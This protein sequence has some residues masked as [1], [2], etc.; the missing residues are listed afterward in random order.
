MENGRRRVW[1]IALGNGVRC[2]GGRGGCGAVMAKE[3]K[4]G[5]MD[6]ENESVNRRPSEECEWGAREG[7]RDGGRDKRIG[8]DEARNS[9][10][11]EGRGASYEGGRQG[12]EDRS[13]GSGNRQTRKNRRETEAGR[14]ERCAAVGLT[15]PIR[16]GEGE[17]EALPLATTVCAVTFTLSSSSSNRPSCSII[18]F[19]TTTSRVLLF[20]LLC[21]LIPPSSPAPYPNRQIES[22]VLIV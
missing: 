7:K 6:R 4:S 1:G 5:G 12:K 14:E 15:V 16:C 3:S 13:R 21:L 8:E 19:T 20:C 2:A 17:E 10:K 22:S 11:R 9:W 18:P